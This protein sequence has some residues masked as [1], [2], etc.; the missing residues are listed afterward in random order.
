[1]IY[2]RGYTQLVGIVNKKFG[3]K[4]TAGVTNGR[5]TERE[6]SCEE[7]VNA[8]SFCTDIRGHTD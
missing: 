5:S 4:P 1:M 3:E 6:T 7:R 8:M 2:L